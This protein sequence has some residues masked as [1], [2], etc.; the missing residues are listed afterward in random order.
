MLPLASF[1]QG[2]SI[3]NLVSRGGRPY[4]WARA[5]GTCGQVMYLSESRDFF[6][7][8]L[9]SGAELSSALGS[10]AVLGRNSNILAR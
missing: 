10:R 7:I 5:A 8:R 2:D 6:V 1:R 9:P 3:F 4:K